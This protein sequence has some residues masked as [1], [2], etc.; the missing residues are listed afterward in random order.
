MPEMRPGFEFQLC[1]TCFVTFCQGLASLSFVTPSVKW[2][3]ARPCQLRSAARLN[4]LI[5]R[6]C[7]ARSGHARPYSGEAP[8]AS[9]T[10]VG[11]PADPEGLCELLLREPQFP[12]LCERSVEGCGGRG[13]Q[14]GYG[15]ARGAGAPGG[16]GRVSHRCPGRGGGQAPAA[17][18]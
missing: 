17:R 7:S 4:E 15:E 13:W 18:P 5:Y 11:A 10:W 1:P 3:G 2:G 8:G 6:K 9:E 16:G 12:Y 14:G